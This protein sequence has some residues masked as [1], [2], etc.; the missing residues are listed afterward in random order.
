MYERGEENT[1]SAD[2][3]AWLSELGYIRTRRADDGQ[4]TCTWQIVVLKNKEIK[5]NKKGKK[6]EKKG[7]QIS[8]L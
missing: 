5:E 3:M 6:E 1:L 4:I 2:D 8:C 7:S